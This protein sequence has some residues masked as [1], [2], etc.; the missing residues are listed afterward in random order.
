MFKTFQGVTEDSQERDLPAP[1]DGAGHLRQLQERAAHHAQE[2]ALR[3]RARSASPSATRSRRATSP[4]APASSSRWSWS[5]SASRA[6]TWSG[7]PTGRTSATTGCSASGMQEENLRLRDHEQGGAVATTPTRP[8]TSSSSSRSAGASCGA[9]PTAPISTSRQHPEHIRAG[10][11]SYFDHETNEK[12]IPY[13]IEPSL[14]ADRVALALPRATPTTRRYWT[15]RGATSASC[16][17]S[18]PRSRP[19][20]R[21][22]CRCPK[23]WRRGARGA[24]REAVQALHGGLRRRRLHRQALPPPGR[25]RHAAAASPTISTAET[26]GCVTVRDRDTMA[27]GAHPDRGAGGVHR[28]PHR[29]LRRKQKNRAIRIQERVRCGSMENN[30]RPETMAR[31]TTEALA[32]RS[33]STSRLREIRAQVGDK[34]GAAGAVRRGRF[35]GR[36]GAAD[37]RRDREAARLRAR[38]PRAAAQGRAGAGRARCS[39]N[40]MDANLMYVDA[41]GPLPG[42]AGRR[43]RSRSRSARSSARSSSACLRR[44]R[45]SCEGIEFL[46]AGHHLSRYPRERHQDRKASRRTTTSAVCRRICSLS[47]SSRSSCCLRTRCA[48]VGKALGLPDEMVY[49]Q[50]FPGPGLGV[51][52]L[53][54]ITRDRLEAVRESDAILREEFAKS[55]PGGQGLAVFHRRARFHV[56]SACSDDARCLR[57]PRHPARGQYRRRHDR[58]RRARALC[59]CCSTSPPASLAEVT[60]VNR[61]LYDLTPKP[62]RHHRVGVN[63]IESIAIIMG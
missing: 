16:C 20:R 56:R 28:R 31:I 6:P 8:P 2:G 22:C 13:V 52:C 3:R 9:S 5:S 14:G 54:A 36:R 50:P 53:G 38:E 1:G 46:G 27:A 21:P 11:W 19:S 49:R 42:Q 37:S 63:H 43:G 32:E 45:A 40:R 33:S 23:S 48:S 47:W 61:V 26:D 39:S 57:L 7:S 29:L 18:T 34:T 12:Y 25:D 62:V 44:R 60:G 24:L 15:D 35:V 41:V 4:S 59:R 58:H 30:K 55:R 51:R 10:S 17:A